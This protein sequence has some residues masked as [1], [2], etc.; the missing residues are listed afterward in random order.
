MTTFHN[1]ALREEPRN[2]PVAVIPLSGRESLLSWLE[3][4]GRF[5]VYEADVQE[6]K[7]TEDLDDILE[8]DNYVLEVEDEEEEEL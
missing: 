3:N 6:Q 7:T 5:N 2:Q 4:T 8:P 1:P